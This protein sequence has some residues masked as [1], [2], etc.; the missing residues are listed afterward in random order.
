M[1]KLEDEFKRANRYARPLSLLLV[2]LDYFKH[3]NDRYGHLAGDAVLVAFARTVSNAIGEHDYAGRYGGEEFLV[4]L[5]DT[6]LG[7]AEACAERIRQAVD[8]LE[9]SF[10]DR[11]I[12]VTSSIGLACCKANV[13]SVDCGIER[14]D[15]ALYRAKSD[16]RNCIRVFD[17]FPRK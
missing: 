12:Q 13:M 16:G 6:S 8:A 5:P 14:A 2:D 9:I 7:E 10:G 3:I 4:V 15:I 17:E 1:R 11:V